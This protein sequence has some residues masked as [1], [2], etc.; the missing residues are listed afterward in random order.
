MKKKWIA[1][2][3]AA[4]MT[5]V[6]AA[7]GKEEGGTDAASGSEG[8]VSESSGEEGE[9]GGDAVA[10]KHHVEITVKDG[11]TGCGCGSHHSGEFPETGG[12]RLL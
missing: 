1:F 4:A 12:G 6:L 8:T 3:L 11:G 10:G 5:L 9:A 7:C 2:V